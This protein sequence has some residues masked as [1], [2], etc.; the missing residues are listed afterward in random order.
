M[1]SRPA[2]VPLRAEGVAG[3][4]GKM[5]PSASARARG[6]CCSLDVL[7]GHVRWV[8]IGDRGPRTKSIE[9]GKDLDGID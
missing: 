1:L 6:S 2:T 4:S 7:P 3:L 5:I 9:T 8:L